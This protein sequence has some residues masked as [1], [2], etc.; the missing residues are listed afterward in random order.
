[1][2][3]QPDQQLVAHVAMGIA[4]IGQGNLAQRPGDVFPNG[5][6]VGEDLSGGPHR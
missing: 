4:H 6:E 2:I 1:M 3:A 5:E